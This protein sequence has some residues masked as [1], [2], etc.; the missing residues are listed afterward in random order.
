MA[1][2]PDWYV[3]PIDKNPEIA[4]SI[5][6]FL[7]NFSV[8]EFALAEMLGVVLTKPYE[9]VAIQIMANIRNISDRIAILKAAASKAPL[10]EQTRSD[11]IQ[12]ADEI[13]SLNSRRNEYVHGLY[14]IEIKPPHRVRLTAWA[15][16]AQRKTQKPEIL[17]T[18]KIDNDAQKIT[19]LFNKIVKR[20]FPD[21]IESHALRT[22]PEK[23]SR[24]S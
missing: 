24:K 17:T 22:S 20:F 16:S 1:D 10:D 4:K 15:T 2:D 11:V 21:R 12:F 3:G 8:L 18:T 23:P 13:V 5:G 6:K 9:G 7:A 14:E 19:D